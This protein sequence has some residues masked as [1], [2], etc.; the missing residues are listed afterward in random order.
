MDAQAVPADDGAPQTDE[1]RACGIPAS[2]PT[3]D[4]RLSRR[5]CGPG[6]LVDEEGAIVRSLGMR[7]MRTCRSTFRARTQS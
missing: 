4:F 6:A 1:E 7:R 3:R 5:W 2:Q